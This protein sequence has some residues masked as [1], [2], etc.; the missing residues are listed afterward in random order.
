MASASSNAEPNVQARLFAR[1][2][3]RAVLKVGTFGWIERLN[4][5]R[6]GAVD[7]TSWG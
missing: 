3:D 1:Q 5:D 7:H 2:L 6:P 4:F